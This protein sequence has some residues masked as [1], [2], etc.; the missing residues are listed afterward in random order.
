MKLLSILLL[1]C[2]LSCSV[3]AFQKQGVKNHKKRIGH[4][5]GDGD[6]DDDPEGTK[7][8][9]A[10]SDDNW[11]L[12]RKLGYSVGKMFDCAKESVE[13]VEGL[14]EAEKKVEAYT[15]GAE[16]ALELYHVACDGTPEDKLKFLQSFVEAA[17][18]FIELPGVHQMLQFTAS[19]IGSIIE[20]IQ[21]W[22]KSV[23]KDTRMGYT[24]WNSG[25]FDDDVK[26]P[27][28]A[29]CELKYGA[30][31]PAAPSDDTPSSTDTPA[32][33]APVVVT[34]N[35]NKIILSSSAKNWFIDH[36]PLL[37]KVTHAKLLKFRDDS[38]LMRIAKHVTPQAAVDE[39]VM[40][41]WIRVYW[42]VA[43]YVAFGETTEGNR[44]C[45]CR[46]D[47]ARPN[48]GDCF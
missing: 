28:S 1:V 18:D 40:K 12:I 21:S 6:G 22:K 10:V 11:E 29:A 45:M 34:E 41:A 14:E 37:E 32:V 4:R 16:A 33:A 2:M 9:K 39:S 47:H 24:I 7:L 48:E 8:A 46:G 26:A 5:R 43:S 35:D 42:P 38:I 19:A 44:F 15:H 17:S 30:G 36:A 27:L 31:A 25:V 13:K 23:E 20:S 3:L